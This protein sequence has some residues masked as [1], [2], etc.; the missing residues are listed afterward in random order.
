MCNGHP[1]T[2]FKK[3]Q[4]HTNLSPL[5]LLLIVH[6]W[7]LLLLYCITCMLRLPC[8]QEHIQNNVQNNACVCVFQYPMVH[9]QRQRGSN[10]WRLR[11]GN[12]LFSCQHCCICAW[13]CMRDHS[14]KLFFQSG[15]VGVS[16]FLSSSTTPSV[17]ILEILTLANNPSSSL[18]RCFFCFIL[19]SS[20]VFVCLSFGVMD[21]QWGR[22][23]KKHNMTG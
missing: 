13:V 12:K 15:N 21:G 10:K 3:A 11:P 17:S 8:K 7:H 4:T 19:H 6:L 16:F 14:A 20:D 1:R 2:P 23:T 18:S 22:R 9:A 5:A